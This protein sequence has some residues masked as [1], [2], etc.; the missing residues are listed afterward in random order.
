MSRITVLVVDDHALFRRGLVEVLAEE[1]DIEVVGEAADGHEAIEKAASL[2]PDVVFMDLNMPGQDGITSTAYLT[3]RWPDMKV[4]ILTVSEDPSD[5]FDVL[6]VGARGYV[7]K[8]ASTVEIADALR[9]VHQGWVVLSPAMAPRFLSD[10]AQPSGPRP[11]PQSAQGDEAATWQLTN[12]ELEV[13][14]LVARH[15]SNVE[16]ATALMISENTVKTHIKSILSK[17][18]AKSRRE[19]LA[20]AERFGLLEDNPEDAARRRR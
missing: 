18:Q 12:R 14:Q 5:L 20:Q 15:L 6:R 4:L 10:L 9:Q 13:L 19:A 16:V 8:T 17:L 1:S 11:A 7:V 2:R 3:Q